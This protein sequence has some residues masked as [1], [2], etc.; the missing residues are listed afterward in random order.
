MQGIKVND[1]WIKYWDAFLFLMVKYRAPGYSEM[2]S[3]PEIKS[4]FW[5]EGKA[6]I[7]HIYASK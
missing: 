5:H 3:F 1:L 6:D 2:G 4:S 7:L